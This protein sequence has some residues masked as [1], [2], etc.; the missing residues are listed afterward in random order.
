MLSFSIGLLHCIKIV[1]GTL[2]HKYI[3]S[4]VLGEL[5]LDKFSPL[6]NASI[7]N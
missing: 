6:L 5:T 4:W 3:V 1:F 2:S 7:S